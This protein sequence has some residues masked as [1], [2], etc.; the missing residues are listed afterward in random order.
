MGNGD[1]DVDDW[2][3]TFLRWGGWV[4]PEQPLWHPA[5]TQPDGGWEPRGQ[6]PCPPAP[7][8]PGEVMGHLINT[9]AMG[10]QLGTPHINTFSSNAT[11]GK[12]EVLFEQWYHEVQ[13]VKDHHP[14]SVVR[15]SIVSSLKGTAADMAD[16]WSLPLVWPT[17]Y[18]N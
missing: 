8:Q 1:P 14:E 11:P 10:L 7:I 6:L 3:V 15:E 4:P 5:P 12:M 9:L 2:E 18:K 17:F 16:I 13:C